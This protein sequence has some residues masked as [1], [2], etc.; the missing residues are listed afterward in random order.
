MYVLRRTVG[1]SIT[2]KASDAVIRLKLVGIDWLGACAL[3]HI[4][5][6]GEPP[7]PMEMGP[8]ETVS[9]HPDVQFQL[10]RLSYA[11]HDGTPARVAEFGIDAPRSIAVRRSET[12][13]GP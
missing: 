12:E 11:T 9:L 3:L 8:G 1:T 2:I 13:N 5:R 7:R 6:N 10:L 4:T